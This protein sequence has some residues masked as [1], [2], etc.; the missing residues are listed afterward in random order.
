MRALLCLL[1]ALCL[2]APLVSAVPYENL[3]VGLT[4]WWRYDNSIIPFPDSAADASPNLAIATSVELNTTEFI[5]GNSSE[6]DQNGDYLFSTDAD[7]ENDFSITTMCWVYSRST[8]AG[9]LGQFNSYSGDNGT[10]NTGYY[11]VLDNNQVDF[12]IADNSCFTLNNGNIQVP[13][14]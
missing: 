12:Y 2:L 11:L 10:S 3:T 4:N 7:M 8:H 13:H 5:T 1:V 14:F 6:Y 9:G